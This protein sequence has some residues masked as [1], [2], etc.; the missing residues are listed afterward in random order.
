MFSKAKHGLIFALVLSFVFYA[1]AAFVTV[2]FVRS[3]TDIPPPIIQEIKN[4][5]TL[6]H[7]RDDH[8]DLKFD[9][10]V[11]SFADQP[12]TIH[13]LRSLYNPVTKET[14]FLPSALL[15]VTPGVVDMG[16]IMNLPEE[17]QPGRWQY[18]RHFVYVPK[19]SMVSRTHTTEPI[20]FKVCKDRGI[21]Q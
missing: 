10:H 3:T 20:E 14:Y 6:K 15:V 7:A 18:I 11:E 13:M 2:I 17:I 16:V 9:S 1:V 8:V 4:V 5:R 12:M 19:F 21:C